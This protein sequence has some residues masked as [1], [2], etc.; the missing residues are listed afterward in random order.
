MPC[1][2]PLYSGGANVIGRLVYDLESH[3]E[4]V[5]TKFLRPFLPANPLHR[6]LD[7]EH[8]VKAACVLS[9]AAFEEFVEKVSLHV[10][11]ECLDRWHSK[12]EAS[13]S[14]LALCLRYKSSIA[15]E[16]DEDKP[17]DKCFDQMRVA[18]E[19]AKKKHSRLIDDNHGFSIKYLRGALTPVFI[20]PPDDFKLISSLKTLAAARGS[21]AHSASRNAEFSANPKRSRA[22]TPMAPEQAWE[23]IDDCLALC[24]EIARDARHIVSG[25]LKVSHARHVSL[26]RKLQLRLASSR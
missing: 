8:E 2:L 16:D 22:R 20:N 23:A 12:R 1:P 5:R 14:L 9:H 18:I 26:R 21:F 15:I 4:A 19:E 7:Y 3:V 17:Q 10:M 13:D 11:E 24:R 6:P 25:P